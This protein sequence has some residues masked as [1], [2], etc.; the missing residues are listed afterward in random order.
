MKLAKVTTVLSLLVFFIGCTMIAA[1]QKKTIPSETKV[2][3][4]KA[5]NFANSSNMTA[6]NDSNYLEFV[7][8]PTTVPFC[9]SAVKQSIEAAKFGPDPSKPYFNVRFSLPIPPVYNEK[10]VG[11]LVGIDSNVY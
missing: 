11:P 10:E 1:S 8:D 7:I 4:V 2:I 3:L 9:Q 6:F 5:A